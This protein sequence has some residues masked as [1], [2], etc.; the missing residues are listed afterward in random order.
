MLDGPFEP[1]QECGA[2]A[3]QVGAEDAHR[4]QLDL[5]R[6]ADDDAGAGR[7]VAVQVDR[8]V[9]HDGR[10]V[11]DDLDGHRLDQP[12]VHDRDACPRCRCR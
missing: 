2:L 7:G 5:G 9:G 4:V 8:L 1:G 11:V 6:Q 12:A 3:A 10:L